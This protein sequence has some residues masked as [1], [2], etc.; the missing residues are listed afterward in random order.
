MHTEMK[1]AKTMGI[2]KSPKLPSG[3]SIGSQANSGRPYLYVVGGNGTAV[4]DPSNWHVV[5]VAPRV[6]PKTG[7]RVFDN[8]Y[9]DQARRVW[10]VSSA[11]EDGSARASVYVTDPKTV[12]DAKTISLGQN[13]VH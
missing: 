6:A 13:V 1:S 12:S 9:L 10:S 2:T 11:T 5:F 7:E 3:A 4:I 8:H